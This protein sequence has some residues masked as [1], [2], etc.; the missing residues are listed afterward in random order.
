ML[1]KVMRLTEVVDMKCI[2]LRC[3]M[4]TG[5]DKKLS[6]TAGGCTICPMQVSF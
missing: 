2:C 1:T 4:H 6:L 5:P 3:A